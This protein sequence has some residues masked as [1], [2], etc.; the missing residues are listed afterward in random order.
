M[1]LNLIIDE[2]KELPEERLEEVYKFVHTLIKLPTN[3]TKPVIQGTKQ[4]LEFAVD[5]L[6]AE[7]KQNKDLTA[8]T[9]LD[10]EEFYEAR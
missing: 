10:T 1:T 4:D 5:E 3:Y 2:L 8:F 7:Y 6:M 9:Q